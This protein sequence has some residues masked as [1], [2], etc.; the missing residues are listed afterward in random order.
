MSDYTPDCW[1]VLEFTTA[2]ETIQKVFAGWYGGF[3]DGD[4]WKLNSGITAVRSDDQGHYE[5]DGYSGSTYYCHFNGYYMNGSMRDILANWLKQAD[6]HGDIKI[7]VL[8][9]DEI[10][11][12]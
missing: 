12:I 10:V 2:K 3:M 8:S 11:E 4:S 1:V 6:E 7:K 5:F 9:L